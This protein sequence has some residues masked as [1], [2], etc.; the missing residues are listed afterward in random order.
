MKSYAIRFYACTISGKE[1][2]ELEMMVGPFGPDAKVQIGFMPLQR[3]CLEFARVSGV[4]C[5]YVDILN[6]DEVD[7]V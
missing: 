2:S 6:I 4:S 3:M 7:M 5:S 1:R